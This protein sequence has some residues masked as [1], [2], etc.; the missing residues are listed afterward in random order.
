[1]KLTRYRSP[2]CS[3]LNCTCP[4]PCQDPH[5]SDC[6]Y[7]SCNIVKPVPLLLPA[8]HLPFSAL[9]VIPNLEQLHQ[10]TTPSNTVHSPSRQLGCAR[11]YCVLLEQGCTT[12]GHMGSG[13][14]CTPQRYLVV[15]CT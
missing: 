6:E 7:I 8:P 2:Q 12:T 4:L 9:T 3:L 1:M 14:C 13:T 10:N 11:M 5:D 15:H